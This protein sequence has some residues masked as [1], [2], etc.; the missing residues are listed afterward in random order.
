MFVKNVLFIV[1]EIKS[2]NGICSKA[3][4][5]CL[6]KKGYKVHCVTNREYDFPK[7]G[8]CENGIEYTCVRPR[9]IYRAESYIERMPEGISKKLFCIAVKLL[10]KAKLIATIPTWPFISASYTRRIYKSS[11][12]ICKKEKIDTVISVYTK[13]DA[14]IAAH[15]I[16]EKNP[17]IQYIP[18]FLDSL[19]G[20]YGPRYFSKEWIIKRGLKW[21]GKLL[22]TADKIVA[23]KSSEEHH[24]RYSTDKPYF[25]N[26]VFLDL[27][28][29]IP[30]PVQEENNSE[31]SEKIKIFYVGTI[32]VQV[33][34]PEG[35]LKAFSN[36]K[37]DKY[38]LTFVG[39][40]NCKGLI[41]KAQ[42][43]DSRFVTC[44]SVSHD[45]AKRLINSADVL[46]NIGN[47]DAS[48]TPSKIFEYMSTGKPIISTAPMANE[49]SVQY[50]EKYPLAHIFKEFSEDD[51]ALC[52]NLKEFLEQCAGKKLD[53]SLLKDVFYL[54]TPQA[55][56]DNIL[57]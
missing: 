46:L 53:V 9:L 6:V 45:E 22:D 48:M 38:C 4:M 7:E 57:E 19:S 35:F 2:A 5:D 29:F 23:M 10:N 33:R 55:F 32:P 34:N 43:R 28:L 11:L 44:P 50:L 16:K 36:I 8:F 1:T 54:N 21:E 15:K 24:Q 31:K 25:K 52:Q 30:A 3:V 12:A 18:Y 39:S 56:I 41:D 47:N 14:L 20:G 26:F 51:D 13:I 17:D 37:G 40:N 42:A 49:P 27:P